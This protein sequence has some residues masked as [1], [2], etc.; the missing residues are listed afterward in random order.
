MKQILQQKLLDIGRK[1]KADIGAIQHAI[2]T[3][4]YDSIKLD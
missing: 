2:D 3:E 1:K 4:E